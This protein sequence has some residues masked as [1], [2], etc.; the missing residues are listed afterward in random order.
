VVVVLLLI[1][2]TMA[3][4]GGR[5]SEDSRP[6]P[7]A[8]TASTERP[9]IDDGALDN[10]LDKAPIDIGVAVK[11]VVERTNVAELQAPLATS[12]PNQLELEL[13]PAEFAAAVAASSPKPSINMISQRDQNHFETDSNPLSSPPSLQTLADP[14]DNAPPLVD[15]PQ[16]AGDG[17]AG[18]VNLPSPVL[19]KTPAG[20]GDW[21]QYLPEIPSP[22]SH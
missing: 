5:R 3:V 4:R 7:A 16:M 18:Q 13:N 21:S 12:T 10:A 6:H 20:I 8:I 2:I 11:G 17:E 1:V 15:E 9:N 14:L 22:H 19:T